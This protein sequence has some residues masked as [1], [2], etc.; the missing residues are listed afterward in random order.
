M[1][2]E[3]KDSKKEDKNTKKKKVTEVIEMEKDGEKKFIEAE[4]T[5]EEKISNKG[6]AEKQRKQLRNVLIGMGMVVLLIIAIMFSWNIMKT[7]NYEGVKFYKNTKE[8]E[9]VTLYNT[10]VPL[11]NSEGKH[12][13]DYNFYLRNSPKKLAEVPFEGELVFVQNM[14]INSE[15][16]FNCDGN[17]IIAIANLNN[18]YTLLGAKVMKDENA[19]C[20][21]QAKY[22]YL[23]II[24]GNETRID[25]VGPACYDIS[26]KDCEILEGT[27]RFMLKT[28]VKLEEAN[29]V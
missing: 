25:Q 8:I 20:D 5:K 13:A 7:I 29:V 26:I 2:K 6:Q 10:K 18:L 11:Y 17:G 21:P 15:E 14:V 4:G 1:K 9:G 3:K 12:H 23:N 22:S 16:S 27:E 19:T 24:K 28:F